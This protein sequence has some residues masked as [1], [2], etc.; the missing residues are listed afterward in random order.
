[1]L[2]NIKVEK[3]MRLDE[4]IKYVWENGEVFG[5]ETEVEFMSEGGCKVTFMDFGHFES[6]YGHDK[7]DYFTVETEEVITED[8]IFTSMVALIWDNRT[9]N[10]VYVTGVQ[11][12]V[13]GMKDYLNK[14]QKLIEVF[15]PIDGKSTSIW[16]RVEE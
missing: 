3:H 14:E 8:K 9:K 6:D 1:M 4:L 2:K 10:Y 12:S 15:V 16:E 5:T 11:E 13:S 7:D